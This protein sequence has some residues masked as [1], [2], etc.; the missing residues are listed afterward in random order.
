[1]VQRMTKTATTNPTV[2]ISAIKDMILYHGS[3][4]VGELPAVLGG[5]DVAATIGVN[6]RRVRVVVD[7]VKDIIMKYLLLLFWKL[8]G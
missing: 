3:F 4:S 2:E 5:C 8:P 6:P 1:M 7:I